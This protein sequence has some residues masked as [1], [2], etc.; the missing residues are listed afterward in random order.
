[1]KLDAWWKNKRE[2]WGRAIALRPLPTQVVDNLVWQHPDPLNAF[3][4]KNR[5]PRPL[6]YGSRARLGIDETAVVGNAPGF[7]K[8]AKI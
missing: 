2:R 5:K 3:V 4:D 1:M 6:A 8:T 7:L